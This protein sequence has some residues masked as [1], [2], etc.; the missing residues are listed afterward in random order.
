MLKEVSALSEKN[1]DFLDPVIRD[2]RIRKL[3]EQL[4][5]RIVIIDGAMGTMIQLEEL[6]EAEFRGTRF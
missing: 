4:E 2:G 1:S 6:G 5:T 3:R